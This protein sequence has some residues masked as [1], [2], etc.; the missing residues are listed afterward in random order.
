MPTRLFQSLILAASIALPSFAGD[1]TVKGKIKH[2]GGRIV[3]VTTQPDGT[4][5]TLHT[6]VQA[7]GTFSYSGN[8]TLPV[9]AEL[10]AYD[11]RL[12]IPIYLEEGVTEVEADAQSPESYDIKGGGELQQCANAFY[13]TE[14]RIAMERDSVISATQATYANDPSF[15]RIQIL[16]IRQQYEEK[17][18]EAEA[19]FMRDNDNLVSA[20]LIGRRMGT[21]IRSKALPE[22]WALLGPTARATIYGQLM[23]PHVEKLEKIIVGGTAPDLTLK[24]P[25][26]KELSIY[27]VKAKLKI[28]D[29]WASWCGP[30]RAENPTVKKLYS[31]YHDKGLEVISISLDNKLDKWKQAIADD[32][33]PW[34]HISDLKGW[35][36]IVTDV[37]EVH[38]IPQL[39]I[40]DENNKIIADGLRGKQ[41]EE[42]VA[43]QLEL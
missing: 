9:S 36:S 31:L 14:R 24:T 38:G 20:T 30:C 34:I 27:S 29:F 39:Y 8:V 26:G 35:N 1:Y 4:L 28:L 21:L 5:D 33:L 6:S 16:G 18:N 2:Q 40:L 12:S 43:R 37:Y 22:R 42:F 13:K 7:D 17:Y 23:K 32:Q 19:A 15:A 10:R 11:S 25:E 41:L 3:L